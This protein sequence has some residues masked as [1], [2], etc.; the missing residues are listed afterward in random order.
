[1][2]SAPCTCNSS[3]M[4]RRVAEH[5]MRARRLGPKLRLRVDLHGVSSFGPGEEH[6]LIRWERIQ[7]I[8][9]SAGGVDVVASTASITLP[10]GAFGL[11]PESLAQELRQASVHEMRGD[12]I[13]RLA[14]E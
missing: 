1:M 3:P 14:G 11:D 12:V 10:P 13:G 9:P 2:A 4:P 7:E 5:V 8:T 6:T